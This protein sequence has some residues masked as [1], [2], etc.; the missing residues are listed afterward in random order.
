MAIRHTLITSFPTITDITKPETCSLMEVLE[1]IKSKAN[2][3]QHIIREINKATHDEANNLKL[4]LP[5]I[6]FSGTFSRREDSGLI[7]YS[8]LVCIDVD[9]IA[10]IKAFRNELKDFPFVYSFFTSPSGKGLKI[11]VFHDFL[12]PARHP[13]I[14]RYV[15]D[16]LGLVG[17]ADLKFDLHCSNLS[18]AC[19]FSYDPKLVINPNAETLKIDVSRL[20][21]HPTASVSRYSRHDTLKPVSVNPMPS[22]YHALKKYK[23][24]MINEIEQFERF[25]SF[26]PGVRNR[27]LN[28]LVCKLRTKGFPEDLV[29]QYLQLYYGGYHNDFRATEIQNCVRSVYKYWP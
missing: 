16:E 15:G 20:Q 4:A 6:C 12:D 2:P 10:D 24:A 8:Q 18:R 13:D 21:S 28:I 17:R 14:Y 5:P 22:D 29:S 3:F 1:G 7:Q 25:H 23:E 19:F 27:N 11:L 26:Y 9:E